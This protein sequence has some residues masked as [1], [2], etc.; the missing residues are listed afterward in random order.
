MAVALLAAVN[1]DAQTKS[2][3]RIAILPF[4]GPAAATSRGQIVQELCKRYSCVPTNFFVRSGTPDW[5]RIRRREAVLAISGRVTGAV[6]ARTLAIEA[7][8][9]DESRVLEETLPLTRNRLAPDAVKTLGGRVDELVRAATAP[10]EEFPAPPLPTGEPEPTEAPPPPPT[11]T[12]P[13]TEPVAEPTPPV[14]ARPAP[15]PHQPVIAVEAGVDLVYRS[16]QYDNLEVHLLRAYRTEPIVAVPRLRLEFH[17]L[18][19]DR[20][21]AIAAL[22]LEA[23]F[24]TDIGLVSVDPADDISYPTNFLRFDLGVRWPLRLGTTGLSLTPVAGYRLEIFEIGASARGTTIV[25][26]PDMQYQAARA[27]TAIEYTLGAVDI[28]GRAELLYPFGYGGIRTYFPDTSGFGLQFELGAG[29]H[30]AAG[31]ELRLRGHYGGYFM[32]FDVQPT[33]RY[34]ADGATDTYSGAALSAR[35]TWGGARP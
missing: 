30:I 32:S 15:D 2:R 4:A 1:A 26:L 34:R 22:G 31:L 14:T 10:V 9:A 8:R 24:L 28:F 23:D 12:P 27:G 19:K 35:Y 16:L 20:R 7:F 11:E 29:V 5:E 33:D 25:G 3:T 6:G 18:A 17:P 21:A 13:P